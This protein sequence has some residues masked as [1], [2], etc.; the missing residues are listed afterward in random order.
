[1]LLKFVIQPYIL[2]RY[3]TSPPTARTDT[4]IM[5][6]IIR[7][8]IISSLNNYRLHQNNTTIKMINARNILQ[9]TK[10]RDEGGLMST[11]LRSNQEREY[12]STEKSLEG[13]SLPLHLEPLAANEQYH[14]ESCQN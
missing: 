9:L 7:S 13:E 8:V 14:Q 10:R 5:L 3:Q 6:Y 11:S 2:T 4:P 1:M 12:L